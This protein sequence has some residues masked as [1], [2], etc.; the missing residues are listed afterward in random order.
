[1]TGG[2]RLL[3]VDDTPA[4][5]RLLEAVLGTE[6]YE[7]A[8]AE[9]GEEALTRMAV[10]DVDAVL[11]DLLMPGIDGVEVCRRLRAD[12]A[13]RALPVLMLT[14]GGE[15]Q[16][17]AALDAG[18]D[19]FL[20]KPFDRAE[21]LA[22]VRSLVRIKRAQDTVRA[23]A[24]ALAEANATLERRVAEQVA[25]IRRLEGL[26]RFLPR[27][28]AEVLIADG[29]ESVLESHRAELALVDVRLRGFAAFA[30][31]VEPEEVT[32][33]LTGFHDG[34][35]DLVE[36]AG[37]TVGAQTGAGLVVFL[38]DPIPSEE[39]AWQAVALAVAMRDRVAR[40]AERWRRRGHDLAFTAGVALGF[41]TVG[42]IG[43]PGRWEYS[44][45]G[46]VVNAAAEL[47]AAAAPG[48]VLITE[49]CHA[50][51]SRRVRIEAGRPAGA[52]GVAIAGLREVPP[53]SSELTPRERE[54][55]E[56]LARGMSNRAIAEALVISE[57]TA[58]RHVANIFMKLGVHSR[59]EATRVALDRGLAGGG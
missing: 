9:S 20:A 43:L 46:P 53:E 18:A 16:K 59:A 14:A 54:V 30:E 11:L 8:T 17:V 28:L 2:G 26:R 52:P 41:A 40:L 25:S 51:V 57:K 1:M 21:L 39:P 33:T 7:V 47:A 13:H 3:V 6:G 48:Q 23:Q 10:G 15:Q 24:L 22:R 37:A 32:G 49:R 56:V 45:V 4:N 5:L 31:R 27:Q 36:R 12:E 50:E 34:V 55:L 38:N 19:D 44:P 42:R 58:I 29:D 35:W